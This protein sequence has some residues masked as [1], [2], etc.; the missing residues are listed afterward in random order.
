MMCVE[1]GRQG[2]CRGRGAK[3]VKR[4][5]CLKMREPILGEYADVLRQKI[6]V[7]DSNLDA[8]RHIA[9]ALMIRSKVGRVLHG[10]LENR[11]SEC[12]IG[13]Q[14]PLRKLFALGQMKPK[15]NEI[16]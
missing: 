1:I 7:T 2:F 3:V 5:I 13:P 16:E 15:L 11:R 4:A 9:R 14:L 12:G 6:L 10:H 8:N